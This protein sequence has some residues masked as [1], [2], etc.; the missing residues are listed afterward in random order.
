[1]KWKSTSSFYN[2]TLPS[3]LFFLRHVP[4]DDNLTPSQRLPRSHRG[5]LEWIHGALGW[6]PSLEIAALRLAPWQGINAAH[7]VV[8]GGKA[9]EG[10]RSNRIK[11]LVIQLLVLKSRE[12]GDFISQRSYRYRKGKVT[13]G[14]PE[15]VIMATTMK[16]RTTQHETGKSF[17]TFQG[18]EPEHE[19]GKLC[20]RCT[21]GTRASLGY[22]RPS[23][24]PKE[25][26]IG[27]RFANFAHFR[28]P[29]PL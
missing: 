15:W 27:S 9:I 23:V 1:M 24:L 20:N 18:N 13:F 14:S 10:V 22:S 17:A 16:E 12:Y 5:S 4:E 19:R 26:P 6:R 21:L 2:W 25:R 28:C 11:I 8:G 3:F 29:A 7:R